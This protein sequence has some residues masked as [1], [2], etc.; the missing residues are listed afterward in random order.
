M[1]TLGRGVME[2]TKI[3]A[4][5]FSVSAVRSVVSPLA[6]TISFMFDLLGHIFQNPDAW[7]TRHMVYKKEFIDETVRKFLICYDGRIYACW[8]GSVVYAIRGRSRRIFKLRIT[9]QEPTLE[10]FQELEFEELRK[11]KYN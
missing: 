2:N 8:E 1:T 5:R 11:I 4:Y 10:D 9:Y 6:G 3:C 7:K